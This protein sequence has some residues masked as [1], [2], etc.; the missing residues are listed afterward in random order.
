M[1]FYPGLK[2]GCINDMVFKTGSKRYCGASA[3]EIVREME[4]DA[5]QYPIVRGTLHQ[6]LKWSL[7][8]LSD[9]IPPRELDL[10]AQLN[11]ETL[12]LSYLCLLEEY[13]LGELAEAAASD[14][15]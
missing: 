9:R 7:A 3:T 10:N 12:A 5:F 8:Q 11:D 4:R 15:S 6:F 2:K 14:R 1:I 13:R